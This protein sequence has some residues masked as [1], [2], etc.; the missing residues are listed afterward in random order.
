M[1][2]GQVRVGSMVIKDRLEDQV[3]ET[4]G[5]DWAIERGWSFNKVAMKSFFFLP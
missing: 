1:G 2:E 4:Y 5:E 3:R